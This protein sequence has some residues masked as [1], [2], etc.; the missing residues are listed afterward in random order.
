MVRK[1]C[2]ASG[3]FAKNIVWRVKMYPPGLSIIEFYGMKDGTV[4]ESGQLYYT[5]DSWCTEHSFDH[6]LKT[7]VEYI[8]LSKV[9][10]ISGEVPKELVENLSHEISI[11]KTPLLVDP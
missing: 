4:V 9:V 5:P 3:E 8:V 7:I 10:Y 1:W 2:E 11:V 6:V